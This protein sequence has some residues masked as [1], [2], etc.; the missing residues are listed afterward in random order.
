MFLGLSSPGFLGLGDG[1]E[2]VVLLLLGWAGL[3]L[4]SWLGWVVWMGRRVLLMA[5][6]VDMISLTI[7]AFFTHS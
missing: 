7:H 2:L 1:I 6:Q 4:F 3:W 5:C